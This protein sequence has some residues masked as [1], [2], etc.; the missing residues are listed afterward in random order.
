MTGSIGSRLGDQGRGLEG[1][2]RD[3]A[4]KKRRSQMYASLGNIAGETNPAFVSG[5]GLSRFQK[6]AEDVD[7]LEGNLK[8][9]LTRSAMGG[10]LDA[11]SRRSV[12]AEEL[13][14]SLQNE[15]HV[16]SDYMDNRINDITR[17]LS[18]EDLSDIEGN[19]DKIYDAYMEGAEEF[20]E[21]F[22]DAADLVNKYNQDLASAYEA[23]LKLEKEL[24]KKNLKM[25]S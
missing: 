21:I 3:P 4:S 25:I 14:S 16:L 20:K 6:K 9:V 22:K 15:G 24:L 18:E 23:Q 13:K 8:D 1:N 19:M 10:G 7:F 11:E 5:S 12:I 17:G 2:M